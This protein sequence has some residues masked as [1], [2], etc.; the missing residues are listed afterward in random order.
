MMTDWIKRKN[1]PSHKYLK[2]LCMNGMTAQEM[3]GKEAGDALVK[4]S[5]AMATDELLGAREPIDY[6]NPQFQEAVQKALLY[7]D[8]CKK[9]GEIK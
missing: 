2:A 5:S 8:E 1:Y 7:I 4:N 9:R 3:F 6:K